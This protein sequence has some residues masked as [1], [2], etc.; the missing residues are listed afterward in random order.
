M[1]NCLGEFQHRTRPGS[2]FTRPR[3]SR[4]ASRQQ[5]PSR[6]SAVPLVSADFVAVGGGL[7]RCCLTEGAANS[8]SHS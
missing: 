4:A 8:W 5:G 2:R 6:T 3:R 7:P 1:P